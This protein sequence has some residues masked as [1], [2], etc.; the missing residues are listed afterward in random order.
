MCILEFAGGQTLEV[1]PEHRFFS[2]G[3]WIPVEDLEAGS[4]L[5]TKNNDYLVIENKTIIPTF[6]EVFNI[7]VLDNENYFVTEDGILVHNGY[8]DVE[9]DVENVESQVQTNYINGKDGEKIVSGGLVEEFPN[10]DV[11][12]QVSGKFEDGTRTVFDDVIKDEAG[13][14]V[15]TNETKTG[16][17][18]YT[19]QQQRYRDGESVT[20]TGKNAEDLKGTTISVN[21][22]PDR[23][24]QV[25][26][27]TGNV[28]KT[29]TTP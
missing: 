10:D 7:E 17:G 11:L 24:S 6:T 4:I 16:N 19:G 14:V 12:H 29:K 15:L 18:S 13:N 23:F 3:E 9:N 28:T 22:T 5:K 26:L 2:G 27:S 21:D 1:T 20:L 25:D 8:G